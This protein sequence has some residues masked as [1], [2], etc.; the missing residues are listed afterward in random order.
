MPWRK[1]I[2][3]RRRW[4]VGL[5]MFSCFS[6]RLDFLVSSLRRREWQSCGTR[7]EIPC[8]HCVSVATGR[9]GRQ[10]WL[11]P[12]VQNDALA[13]NAHAA[14]RPWQA[15][16]TNGSVGRSEGHGN[17]CQSPNSWLLGVCD[18]L[19]CCV[20][21]LGEYFG[22]CGVGMN[23]THRGLQVA[24]QA[25]C[26]MGTLA[27]AAENTGRAVLGP[28]SEI[29]VV[30]V[31]NGRCIRDARKRLACGVQ[32]SVSVYVT[33]REIAANTFHDRSGWPLYDASCRHDDW[34][35]GA[36]SEIADAS[37]TL[38]RGDSGASGSRSIP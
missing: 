17:A 10:V 1:P 2:M 33:T 36:M 12:T 25:A 24:I 18:P 34:Q 8:S 35:S 20:V 23:L 30:S 14:S 19:P 31:F 26:V 22:A 16:V 13:T 27:F 32:Q 5:P 9:I 37:I 3:Q 11:D 38:P 29:R 7:Q 21:F 6:C 4:S 28:P 15:P